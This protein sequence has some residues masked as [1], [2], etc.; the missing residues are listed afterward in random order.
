MS[1]EYDCPALPICRENGLIYEG[2]RKGGYESKPP[3]DTQKC[4]ANLIVLLGRVLPQKIELHL[5]SARAPEG[6]ASNCPNNSSNDHSGND[7]KG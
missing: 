2:C 7:G 5:S 4:I 1:R 3:K 6:M